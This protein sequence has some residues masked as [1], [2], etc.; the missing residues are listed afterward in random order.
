MN[1]IKTKLTV[2]SVFIFL[3]FSITRAQEGNTPVVNKGTIEDQFRSVIEKSSRY[4]DF[5]VVKEVSLNTLR[6]NVLDTLKKLR[7]SLNNS[8]KTIAAHSANIDSV[9]SQLQSTNDKLDNTFKEKNSIRFLGILMSKEAYSRTMWIII[10]ILAIV[11]AIFII[12]FKRSN[13]ITIQNKLD[14]QETRDEFEKFRKRA[15]QREQELSRNHLAEL[16]KYKKQGSG[17]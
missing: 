13:K 7:T 10:G 8:N 1:L 12:M 6:T 2:F 11:L 9:K 16:N 15:L 17:S 5:K 3:T 4:Q 14:L